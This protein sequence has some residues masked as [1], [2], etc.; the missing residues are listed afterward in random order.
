MLK[1]YA[2]ANRQKAEEDIRRMEDD[3][4]QNEANA[5]KPQMVIDQEEKN[6]RQA[7]DAVRRM[8]D[9]TRQNEANAQKPQ[10][11]IDQDEK[12]RQKAE[13]DIR[14]MEDDVRQNEANAQ[15]TNQDAR[16]NAAAT[17]KQLE[18]NEPGR[19]NAAEATPPSCPP[20]EEVACRFSGNQHLTT[21]HGERYDFMGVGVFTMAKLDDLEVQQPRSQCCLILATVYCPAAWDAWPGPLLAARRILEA[22]LSRSAPSGS[23]WCGRQ[24]VPTADVAAF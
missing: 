8:D 9:D 4:R 1:E 18:A 22:R 16:Q 19:P 23:S 7:E 14:R 13:E 3:V 11:V 10:V 6:R 17:R 2:E 5:Q 15:K 12:N 24:R 21:Y 20:Y